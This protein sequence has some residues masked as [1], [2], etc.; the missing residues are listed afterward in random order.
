MLRLR[1]WKGRFLWDLSDNMIMLKIGQSVT[2]FFL[3]FIEVDA[4]LETRKESFMLTDCHRYVVLL[5]DLLCIGFT[6]PLYYGD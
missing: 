6:N 3:L 1:D 4:L 5:S 2:D